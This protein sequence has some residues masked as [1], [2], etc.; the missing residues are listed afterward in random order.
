MD[1][2]EFK[3]RWETYLVGP[4]TSA[5]VISQHLVMP[6]LSL[7]HL[8]FASADPLSELPDTDLESVFTVPS[9]PYFFSVNT[10]SH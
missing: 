9:R 10:N 6:L 3:W 2:D 1:F 8:A 7:T 5:N 4:K